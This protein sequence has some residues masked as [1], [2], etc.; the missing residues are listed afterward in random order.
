MDEDDPSLLFEDR[1]ADPCHLV[2]SLPLTYDNRLDGVRHRV[3]MVAGVVCMADRVD[4]VEKLLNGGYVGI[5][6][7]VWRGATL[8]GAANSIEMAE[9]LINHGAVFKGSGFDCFS[10][11]INYPAPHMLNHFFNHPEF[12]YRDRYMEHVIYIYAN[13]LSY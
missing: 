5:N 11:Y 1:M 4:L 6:D 3:Q 8:L 12:I 13:D 7:H 10:Y 2:E 9:V